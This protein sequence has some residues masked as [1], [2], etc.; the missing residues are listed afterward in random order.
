MSPLTLL[1]DTRSP[2]PP[3]EQVRTQLAALILSGQLPLGERLPSVRQLAAD[4]GLAAGTLAR[5]YRELENAGLVH[6]RRG[7]GTRVTRPPGPTPTTEA[8]LLQAAQAYVAA[9]RR[10]G[11][12][13][14]QLTSA[15][16]T[17]LTPP[18]PVSEDRP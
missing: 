15:L 10:L 3:Y 2:V 11:A 14:E 1:V 8:Q 5:A 7:A 18:S 6:S 9:G 17:A 4:L 12:D 16:R 13:D